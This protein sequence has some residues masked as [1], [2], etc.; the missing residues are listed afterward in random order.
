M[1]F[2]S[3]VTASY[4]E[5]ASLYYKEELHRVL[6]SKGINE[7]GGSAIGLGDITLFANTDITTK[8]VDKIVVGLKVGFPTGKAD[9]MR[10]LWSPSLSANDKCFEFAAFASMLLN[11][12]TYV[13]PHLSLQA[14][15]FT[16]SHVNK[17][18]PHMV[19]SPANAQIGL[20]VGDDVM[21]MGDRVTYK[22]DGDTPPVA[23]SFSDWDTTVRG[24]A[25]HP[26]GVKFE[27]GT[28]FH[29]R[30]G[31][32]FEKFISRRGFFDIYYD[33][34]AKLEDDYRGL[35]SAVY[36]I[37]KM[38]EN[39]DSIENRIGMEYT[40]QYGS[41]TYLKARLNYSFAGI[42]APKVFDIGLSLGHSF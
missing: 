36:D 6:Q 13:N 39:T 28:E 4:R 2:P 23:I 33:L 16:T 1:H 29:V 11:H 17:R 30:L 41:D 32:V 7:L 38:E 21:A 35:N 31:N 8:Y 27:K 10:K 34:R 25:D 20:Q 40:Q 19:T 15:F 18:V 24:F 37:G 5:N 12:N 3:S 14:S 9:S 42:N 22:T 26:V